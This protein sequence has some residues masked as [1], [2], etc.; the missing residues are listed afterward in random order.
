MACKRLFSVAAIA[1]FF[2]MGP[3]AFGQRF[4]FGIVGGASLTDDFRSA[5][6]GTHLTEEGV[7]VDVTHRFYSTS[8]DYIVGPMVELRLP[9]RLSVEADGLYRPLNYTS[10]AVNPDGSLNSISPATVVTWEFPVLAK[11]GSPLRHAQP[12]I[13]VGPSF[14][15]SGNLNNAEPSNHGFTAGV[16][17]EARLFGRLKL[18]PVVR[19]TRWGRD[20]EFARNTVSPLTIK[21][22]VEFL[23]GLSF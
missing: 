16:G 15:S 8:K 21:D 5:A 11:Y 13:E 19:Y 23:V 22:Q 20:G 1:V 18:A 4:S 3:V 9:F 12:F 10:G 2:L 7:L 6:I 17:L 14:R